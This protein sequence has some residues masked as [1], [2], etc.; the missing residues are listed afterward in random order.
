MH[1]EDHPLEYGGFEGE[2]PRGEYGAG[3]VT[4]W[5]HGRYETLKWAPD[6]VKVRLHG[7]RVSGEFALFQTKGNQWMIHRDRQPLPTG[8]RPMLATSWATPPPDDGNWALE[9]KWDGVRALAFV[10]RGRVRLMSRTER[11]ITV[12][13]PELA[14]LGHATDRKQLLLDGEI[15]VFG[16]GGWPEFEALQPRMHVSDASQAKMLAGQ[17]PVIYL[18]FDVLQLDGRPLLEAKYSDRRALLES[19]GL[20]GPYWQTPPSFPGEDFPAVQ[21]VSVEHGMEGVV[22]KRLDSKYLPGER[23]DHWRKIKNLRRQEVVVAGYKPGKGNRTGQVG[24]LLI[25]V[26][27]SS[28]LIYAGHVGTGFSVETLRMLG[29]RLEPLR[30]PDSPYRGPGA[31]RACPDRGVG[32]ATAGDRGDL[33]QVDQGRPDAGA[34]V[35]GPARR[36]GSGQRGPGAAVSPDTKVAVQVD[37]RTLTLTNLGKVLY[38]ESG[39]TKAEV[40]DYYQRVAPVLLPHIAGRPLTLKRY[41]EG[42]DGEAFFQK[43][44]TAHR[45]DW[46]RTAR[47]DSES[48]R[49]RG[50]TVTYLVVDDLPALIWA[51]NLA[52]LEL[53]APMWRMPRIREPDL[54]VFDLDPGAPANIVDCCRV[55]EDLRPLLAADGLAP[56]AKTSGGKGLQLYA[57]ISGLTSEQASDRARRY[58]E[59]LEHD[60]P[61]RAV[62]RMTK[63]LRTGKVLIDWSQN[64]GSKT[65]VAPYSLRARQFPTV[66][67]PV[68]WDEVAAC[69]Q[70]QDLFFTADVVLD[71]VATRGDL[72][73]PLLTPGPPAGF[74]D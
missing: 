55:A 8:I 3:A 58:A 67:T 34:G 32:R 63:A 18:V 21:A 19:L 12:A 6:E 10:E 33:R 39:F 17:N 73:A 25:G 49:A 28:G 41:P 61:R 70:P 47:V 40:L 74:K 20:A 53:H 60:Q 22:A 27:D 37:G 46:I 23:T 72:F 50:T 65:T 5:D 57:A 52:G 1:T 68:S 35:Q 56:L 13:Y 36:Q 16:E 69:R 62:S 30:R 2:I 44:V 66:S 11:D 59:R 64:N 45:P 15:V 31:A 54:L 38:P 9:M 14:S 24:S 42:V 51:A 43:H 26:N 7:R 71:R 4:I 29:Q 48:S